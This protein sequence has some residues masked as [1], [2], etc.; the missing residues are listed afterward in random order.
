MSDSFEMTLS[1]TDFEELLKNNPGKIIIKLGADWC[2]P[3]KQIESQVLQAFRVLRKLRQDVQCIIVDVDDSF[4]LY[5]TLRKKF[6]L[7][8]IPA[9][10]CYNS[11]NLSYLPDD[12]IVGANPKG[13]QD[14][15]NRV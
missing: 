3:C 6:K 7:N 2:G 14:F 13:I 8:G 5:A 12:L 1:K 4:E 10:L 9:I 11:E 15:F